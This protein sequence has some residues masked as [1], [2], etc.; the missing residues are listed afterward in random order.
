[1]R[2]EQHGAAFTHHQ[3]RPLPLLM[4]RALALTAYSSFNLWSLKVTNR[5]YSYAP[6]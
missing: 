6:H 3:R 2:G 4:P 1:M 5:V